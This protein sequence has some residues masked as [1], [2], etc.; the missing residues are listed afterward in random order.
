M[1]DKWSNGAVVL[2][3][4]FPQSSTEKLAAA[5]KGGGAQL[6]GF[7]PCLE[8]NLQ[9]RN[10]VTA[11]TH[12]VVNLDAY[13]D[14]LHAVDELLALRKAAPE[15]VVLCV[16]KSVRA[17]DFGLERRQICHATL[18]VPF[19]LERLRAA[20]IAATENAVSCRLSEERRDTKR[21]ETLGAVGTC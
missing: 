7:S 11:F 13:G 3:V 10:L 9:K 18:R 15:A 1:A 5:L 6:V 20:F 12:F 4:G 2:G 19:G 16:S 17:D 8:S 21:L 14:I